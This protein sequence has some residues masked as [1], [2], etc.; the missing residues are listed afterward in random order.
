MF[1]FRV[2]CRFTAILMMM[3]GA[4]ASAQASGDFHVLHMFPLGGDGSWDYL[5]FDAASNRHYR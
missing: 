3:C 1:L 4:M 2:L 5:R